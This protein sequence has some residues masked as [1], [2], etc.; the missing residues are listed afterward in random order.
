MQFS[1]FWDI[2]CPLN[3]KMAVW[4]GDPAFSRKVDKKAVG[5]HTWSNSKMSL[6]CHTGT[7]MDAPRHVFEKG[8]DINSIPLSTLVGDCKVIEVF[9]EEV[10]EKSVAVHLP[11]RGD[12]ILLKTTN[13]QHNNP[14]VFNE[15]YIYFTKGA[16]KLLVEAQVMLVGTDGPSVDSIN[17]PEFP[18]HTLF[19]EAGVAVLE[20]LSLTEV[21]PGSYTLICL[22]MK[23]DGAD[24]APV[25]AILAR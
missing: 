24:G 18:A 16:A 17:G 13:S 5:K 1:R 25:R 3:E 19:C 2:T 12:R 14:R 9:G 4:P 23:I 10:D 22:P 15:N 6:G 7:H 8:G 20:N 11:R 21:E